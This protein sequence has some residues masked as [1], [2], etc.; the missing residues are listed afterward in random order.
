M[1]TIIVL[2]TIG[3]VMLVL[4]GEFLVTGASGLARK[5]RM[6]SLLIGLTIVAFGTSA[7][8]LFISVRSA[9]IGSPDLVMGNVI[10]SNI[11]NLALVL[12]V[13]ALIGSIKITKEVLTVNWTMTMASSILL[14]YVAQDG[15]ISSVEGI[16]FVSILLAYLLLLFIRSRKN[17]EE[18]EGVEIVNPIFTTASWAKDI[19]FF[20]GG[21]ILLSYGSKFL[22]ESASELA[23][24]MEVSER[25][26]A[27][28]VIAVGTSL[29]ELFT[30]IIAAIKKDTD[31][32]LGN[33]LGSNIF[34]ILSILG[35]T[36]IIQDIHIAAPFQTE[37][38]YWVL[39]ITAVLLPMMFIGKKISRVDGFV[40]F[41]LYGGYIALVIMDA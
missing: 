9:L 4:G 13:T 18:E 20:V 30:S 32:A 33:L 14:F 19:I 24:M 27:I 1:T 34:N 11:C 28:V 2:G 22:V 41:C 17:V 21:L 31:L 10:G 26:I 8:E 29:P 36:S 7:P 37:D 38:M 5:L 12:G 23:K 16:I 39:G 25:I 15:V 3:L 40:L 6:S 35:I